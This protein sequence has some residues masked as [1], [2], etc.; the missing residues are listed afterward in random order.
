MSIDSIHKAPVYEAFS[1]KSG[2]PLCKIYDRYEKNVVNTLML[3]GVMDYNIRTLTNELGF[4]DRHMEQICFGKDS[5]SA[6]LMFS[7]YLERHLESVKQACNVKNLKKAYKATLDGC[8]ICKT[9][10]RLMAECEEFIAELYRETSFKK[11]FVQ[12]EFFC[13]KHT[14]ELLNNAKLPKKAMNELVND[15]KKINEKFGKKTLEKL[16]TYSTSF[17]YRNA[18]R[19]VEDVK[20]C[21]K[22]VY[23]FIK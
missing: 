18:G 7:T 6:S 21:N 2:C 4:C 1:H 22:D 12:Q 10:N 11:L 14:L 3:E 8:Y 19:S 20:D 13:A 16:E 15:V 5:L 17:D 23:K 9:L